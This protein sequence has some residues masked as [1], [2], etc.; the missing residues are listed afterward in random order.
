MPKI[1]FKAFY[2]LDDIYVCFLILR[3][4][5]RLKMRRQKSEKSRTKSRMS[6]KN[7]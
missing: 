5:L 3:A 4:F 7:P 1:R 2:I 6:L